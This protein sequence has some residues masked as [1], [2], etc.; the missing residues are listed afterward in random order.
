VVVSCKQAQA[1]ASIDKVFDNGARNRGTVKSTGSSAKLI[2][3][4]QTATCR[5]S[6]SSGG[7]R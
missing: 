6:K 3:Y 7:L 5:S 2:H 1:F 4:Y